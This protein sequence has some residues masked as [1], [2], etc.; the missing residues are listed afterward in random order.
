MIGIIGDVHGHYEELFKTIEKHPTIKAWI[1]VGDLGG[2]EYSYPDFPVP[3]YFISGN[4][5]SWDDIEKIDKGQGPKNLIHI[6]NGEAVEISDLKILGFGGNYSPSYSGKNQPLVGLRRRHN[7]SAEVMRASLHKDVDI[8]ITHEPP[9]PYMLRGN[10]CGVQQVNNIL[11]QVKP[12]I[13]FFGHHHY[14]S[15]SEREGINCVGLEYAWKS[16]ITLD[17]DDMLYQVVR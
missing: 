9:V 14:Y 2:E 6:K 15:E 5:E 7:T 4:H 1:Q 11:I 8:F 16:F 3:F 12:K 10:D 13:C 17:P